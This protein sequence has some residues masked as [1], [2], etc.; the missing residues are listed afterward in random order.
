M[1]QSRLILNQIS[2]GSFSPPTDV[3]LKLSDG[4]IDAHKMILAAVS[5]VFERMFYGD[6]KEG[7]AKGVELPKDNYI[8]MKLLINFVY[9]GSCDIDNV[10]SFLPLTAAFDFYQ[11]NK[12][13]LQ[14]MCD[15]AILSQMDCSNYL[16]LLPKYV[17]VMSEEGHKKA[18]DKVMSYTNNDFVTKFDQTKDLPEEVMLPLLQRG[19][20]NC[21]EVDIFDFLTKWHDYQMQELGKSLNL[22]QQLF[23]SIRYQVIVPQVLSSKIVDCVHADKHLLSNAYKYMHNSHSALGQPIADG[24]FFDPVSYCSRKPA[25]SCKVEWI[26]NRNVSC[27]HQADGA[28]SLDF[29]CG[30]T[31]WSLTES[32]PLENGIYTFKVS[33][34]SCCSRISVVIIDQS[35]SCLY[36][37]PLTNDDVVTL[38]VHDDNMFLKLINADKALSTVCISGTK[39]FK[40]CISSNSSSD[41]S[42]YLHSHSFYIYDCYKD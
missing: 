28:R 26:V 33:N 2:P 27:S 29:R 20:I 35:K 37:R 8:T 39:P 38:S 30:D 14:H 34:I 4:S 11:I 24:T 41:S 25:H 3:T 40:V 7:N 9:S 13:P 31:S 6:F 32:V 19:D 1:L 16:T 15:E 12:A 18:A 17:S 42:S 21:H 36:T 23:R 10:D 22:I 5:P